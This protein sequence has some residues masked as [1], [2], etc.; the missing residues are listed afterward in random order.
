[1]RRS[2]AGRTCAGTPG[3][4]G[5][6]TRDDSWVSLAARLSNRDR[7]S[8]SCLPACR[9]R[10]REEKWHRKMREPRSDHSRAAN[11]EER[12]ELQ[13]GHGTEATRGDLSS[14]EAPLA[15][16][17]DEIL[18]NSRRQKAENICTAA[19]ASPRG[20]CIPRTEFCRHKANTEY[21][22]SGIGYLAVVPPADGRTGRHSRRLSV[23]VRLAI[24][25]VWRRAPVF[26]TVRRACARR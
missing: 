19:S 12:T 3:T 11:Q 4:S 7:R 13:K 1:M 2:R 20:T 9:T 18:F 10:G 5:P 16:P 23:P 17:D 21:R 8:G 26:A 25:F 6:T 15:W 14:E 24:L 22:T